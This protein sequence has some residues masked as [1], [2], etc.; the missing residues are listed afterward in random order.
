MRDISK[1]ELITALQEHPGLL[2][3]QS[4]CDTRKL[5]WLDLE[6]YHIYEGFFHKAV[7]RFGA[8][9][10]SIANGATPLRFLSDLTVLADSAIL[11]QP[12]EPSGFIFHC[13]RSGST[14][15][16]KVLARDRRHLVIGEAAAHNQ[17][18]LALT[19]SGRTPLQPTLAQQTIYRNLVLA[20]GR[21]RTP[22]YT[23][24]FVKFTSFNVL[25]IDFIRSVFP[26]VPV[27]FLYR[28]PEQILASFER[29]PAPWLDQN[30]DGLRP[31][32]RR[33][34]KPGQRTDTL[35]I[36]ELLADFFY[37]GVAMTDG[38]KLLNYED[39]TAEHLPEILNALNVESTEPRMR[40]MQTQ[41]AFDAKEE[42]RERT[43]SSKRTPPKPL[44]QE[45]RLA[46]LYR[47]LRESELNIVQS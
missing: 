15:L 34:M 29:D 39:L 13:G 44:P 4:H 22:E 25:F 20:M 40:L 23:R 32:L 37:A 18:L 12:G 41:F 43:F 47:Q 14:L 19:D 46:K 8:L 28:A 36:K 16:T 24:Y 7:D 38:V 9:K 45:H 17:V 6:R 31:L 1:A 27:I 35:L 11:C 30:Q 42:N 33:R 3:F 21:R 5:E 10:H 2:P 26:T